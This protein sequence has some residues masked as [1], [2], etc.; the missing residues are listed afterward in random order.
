MIQPQTLSRVTDARDRRKTCARFGSGTTGAAFMTSEAEGERG[1]RVVA[2]ARSVVA[3][4][5]R[6]ALA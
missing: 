2:E 6:Q 3:E 5:G 4:S 1:E